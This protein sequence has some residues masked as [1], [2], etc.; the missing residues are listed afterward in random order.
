MRCK[1][2]LQSGIHKTKYTGRVLVH[3]LLLAMPGLI[4][5]V[6]RVAM[7]QG[8][9]AI[10]TTLVSDVAYRA[11]GTPASGTV[12]VSWGA[13]T[14]ARGQTVPSGSTSARIGAGGALSVQL[15][16]NAGA[17]PMG[18]YYTAVYHLDD[19]S[20]SREYWVVPVSTG[21]VALSTI[22][23]TVLPTSVA[24]QT[25]SKAYVDTAIAAA[26]TGTPLASSTDPYL[27]KAGDTMTGPLV[28]AGDPTA[29]TQAADKHYVDTSVSALA[30]G[31]AQ[32]VSTLPGATQVVTQPT[33]TQ[34]QVNLLNGV[35]YASQY[36]SG[37]GNNGIANAAASPDCVGGCDIKADAGYPFG[38]IYTPQNWNSGPL[39]GTR[40]E[41]M[42][43]GTRRANYFNPVD[44]VSTG[45]DAGET[46]D[47]ASTRSTA[48]TFQRTGIED[49]ASF[50]MVIH[51]EGLAGGSN[52]FP[53]TQ[54]A[55]P[56]F[57]TA[58]SALS[59]TGTYN[60]QGQHVLVPKQINCYGV[61]DCLIGSQFLTAA[62]GF[63][64]EADEGTHPFDLQVQED[65]LVFQGMCST[66][67]STGSTLLTVVTTAA[68]GTQGE[69]RFLIN[70]NA[71]RVLSTG[72][73]TGGT[74]GTVSAIA[75]FSGTSFPLSVLMSTA[76]TILSQAGDVAP[77]T[78]IVAIATSSVPS[79]FVT[80]TG[81][82]ATTSGVA[83]V[84]DQP[85]AFVPN[86]YEM[87]NY[88]V[89]D[90]TH[91]RMTVN[92]VHSARATIAIGGL[93]G[94]GLE[95]TVDTARGIRQVFPVVGSYSTTGLYYAGGLT[96]ILGVSGLTSSFLN[97]S[98]SIAAIARSGNVVTV[99][100]AGNLPVD[101]NG[102][103][104]VVNGVADTSYNGS[105]AVTT[106]GPNTLTY[107]GSGA[108]STS[109]GG[110]VSVVTGGYAL[111]PMAEVLKVY[112]ATTKKVDGQMILAA[113]T[114]QWATNDPVEEPHYFQENVAADTEYVG[115]TTPR[116]ITY[117]QAGIQYQQ[118]VGPGIRGWSIQNVVPA[119][120]YL[121]NGGTH[122]VPD[123]AF[124]SQGA[125]R[126]TFDMQ[127]GDES[128]F[129]VHCN[130]HGCGKWNSGYN[131]FLMDSSVGFDSIAFQPQTSNLNINMRGTAYG[132]TPLAFTA[133]TINASTVNA[134][135]LNGAVNAAQLPVFVASG[136]SHSQG[137]VPDPGANA[138]ASRY[139]R[140]DGVWVIPTGGGSGGGTATVAAIPAG[141]TADYNF[142]QGS[143]TALTDKSGNGNSATLGSGTLAPTWTLTG[144]AFSGQQNVQLPVALNGAKTILAGIYINPLTTSTGVANLYPV[145]VSSSLGG[146]GVNLLYMRYGAAGTYTYAP[147]VYAG[148]QH[149]TQ[150]PNLMSGFHVL[151]FVLGTGNGNVDHVYIDGS[152]VGY[153][154]EGVSFG[155]QSG[156]NYMLG[157]SNTGPFTASGFNGMFYR[158]VSYATQ[159]TASDVQVA[160]QAIQVLQWGRCRRIL[161]FLSF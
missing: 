101:V 131:L 59:V 46:I 126:R 26:V 60:T 45:N 111:Y 14:T 72:V 125:W 25:V 32:K 69:G 78:V 130:S 21:V 58:Y 40:V 138:G 12:I 144:L 30:S 135:T 112:N 149:T 157:S 134:T 42:R 151:C 67:C 128:V 120:D 13:F 11:D 53:A 43:G 92:K 7:A 34:L 152:E 19:G 70:K 99:T 41:D 118:N 100:T 16:S 132:F 106:T 88:T 5:V 10:A 96:P 114:V 90:G 38:E 139:L 22:R 129:A 148:N 80:N 39:S 35:E 77:G 49:I 142:L 79:G 161:E 146:G 150:S 15:A 47:V 31:L 20:V 17:T 85:N 140:E 141:A 155:F 55:V 93:C 6:N 103:T 143:G 61:G 115:Q 122:T 9:S 23:S 113:N 44:P 84:T 3:L 71:A 48:S 136:S 56:Y 33:G 124:Q 65:P 54:E 159:L 81:T 123:F 64:D 57:K 154:A 158:F 110:K 105:F 98:L 29:I 75:T 95:Q 116:P 51:H 121:G 160:S 82:I 97:M 36:V 50:G 107:G 117:T 156:G 119:T 102:L 8:A 104:L 109:S 153:L 68:P 89:V 94:Y 37:T 63:R 62:G 91:L 27:L 76:Q 108:N 127:A 52:L 18:S 145:L 74:T 28:L 133:G 87:A 24:M 4:T 2:W 147:D 73:L 83:C 66:G 86:N 137:A 1:S